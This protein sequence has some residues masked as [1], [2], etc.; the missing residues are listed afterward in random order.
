M[1]R[2]V[3]TVK[4][5]DSVCLRSFFVLIRHGFERM[6]IRYGLKRTVRPCKNSDRRKRK[7]WIA[8]KMLMNLQTTKN[9][10]KNSSI[11]YY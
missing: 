9:A 10:Y 5:E 11:S 4:K 6:D 1:P 3:K 8:S 7:T 2:T